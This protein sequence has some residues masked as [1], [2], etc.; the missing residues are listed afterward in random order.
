[1]DNRVVEA[2]RFRVMRPSGRPAAELYC[3]EHGPELVLR[4]AEGQPRLTMGETRAGWALAFSTAAG[5]LSE[6]GTQTEDSEQP[7]IEAV[8]T[9]DEPTDET[10]GERIDGTEDEP[11]EPFGDAVDRWSEAAGVCRA[12]AMGILPLLDELAQQGGEPVEN[13]AT[14][15]F[16]IHRVLVERIQELDRE[17]AEVAVYLPDAVRSVPVPVAEDEGE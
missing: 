1:M 10:E 6:R 9:E 3:G 2:E 4:D 14:P 7:E 16:E 11:T 5:G 15:A 13:F 8:E 12:F 17:I